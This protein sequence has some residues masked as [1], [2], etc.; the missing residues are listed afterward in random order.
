MFF[1]LF[2][3]NYSTKGLTESTFI[4]I[5]T[6]HFYRFLFSLMDC[7]LQL[8]IKV[9]TGIIYNELIYN[10]NKPYNRKIKKWLIN[11]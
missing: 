1:V 7:A 10:V 4:C 9:M 6:F 8:T 2:R 11:L 3:N 5:Y